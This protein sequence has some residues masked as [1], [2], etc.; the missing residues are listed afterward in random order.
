MTVL[1]A[2]TLDRLGYG[3]TVIH[4]LDPRGKTL[5]TLVFVLTVV[6]FP[7]Y[8]VAPLI[9]LALFPLTLM[10]LGEIPPAAILKRTAAVSPFAVLVGMFNPVF[11]TQPMAH[12]AGMTITGGWISFASILLRFLLTVSAA[13]ALV[14]TTSFPR[15][16]QGLDAMK[17]PRAF[18]VQMLFLYRYLFVLVEEGTRLKRAR[19]L[20]RFGG[21]HGMG[22]RVAASLIGVLFLRTYERAERIYLAMCARGFDGHLRLHQGLRFGPA[23]A[24]FVAATVAACTMLR[25]FPVVERLGR[26]AAGWT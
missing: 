15:I 19:D 24:L 22:L 8:A 26:W 1:S 20:R 13:L 16:C 12:I 21:R 23:D 2:H 10:I 9:P 6:S 17:V 5:A 11:D 25:F 4:R 18:I 14:A 7:K 3:D